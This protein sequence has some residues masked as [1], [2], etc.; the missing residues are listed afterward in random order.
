MLRWVL[1]FFQPTPKKTN[2]LIYSLKSEESLQTL[3][4]IKK[5]NEHNMLS[6][7]VRS[8]NIY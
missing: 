4:S 1:N 2:N 5:V 3:Q 8:M 6:T 7:V